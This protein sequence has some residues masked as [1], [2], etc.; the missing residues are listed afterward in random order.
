MSLLDEIRKEDVWLNFQTYKT[1]HNQLSKCEEKKLASFIAQKGYSFFNEDYVFSYPEKIILSR[2]GSDKKRVVYQYRESE[3]WVLKLI[4]FLLY[5][6]DDQLAPNCYSFR[7]KKTA[8]TAWQ[9]IMHIRNLEEKT[10]LKLD[11]HDYFNSIDTDLLIP[12]LRKVICDDEKLLNLLITLLKQDLCIY[13][14]ELISEKRGA[15][16]G[17]PLASFFANVYLTEM[18]TAFQ[19]KGIP[20]FRYSDDL[21]LFFDNREDMEREYLQIQQMIQDLHLTLNE[22]KFSVSA[23]HQSWD[24]L[25]FSYHAG[26]I[27]LSR[28]TIQK[29]KDKIRRKAHSIYRKRKRKAIPYPKAIRSMVQSFDY[30]FYDMSGNNYFTWTRFYFPVITTDQG[31]HEIDTYMQNYLRYLYSGRH[32]K[33]NFR[34]S[35][36]ELKKAGYTPLVAEYYNWK[37]ENEELDRLNTLEKSITSGL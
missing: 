14:G 26:S 29:M 22:K 31:L 1:E 7:R 9:D 18:D 23:P 13:Q 27:D 4:A 30:K 17:V 11:I 16:A 10:V 3:M 24:F 2:F 35:Y 34:V 33:G 37:K 6:Y 36:E 21:L 15:M 25:G 20:C 28:S 8:K 12:M 32:N 19:K 5:R